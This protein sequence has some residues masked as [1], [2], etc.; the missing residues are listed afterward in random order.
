LNKYDFD[1][2]GQLLTTCEIYGVETETVQKY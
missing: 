2:C 1:C